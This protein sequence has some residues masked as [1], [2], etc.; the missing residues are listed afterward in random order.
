MNRLPCQYAVIRFLPYAETGEFANVGIVLACPAMGYLDS[1]LMPS[2]KTGRITGFF[3]QLDIRIYREA[4]KYLGDE[5][6]RVRKLAVDLRGDVVV[7]QLFEGLTRP[8]EAL[9]RF[10][11]VR[12]VLADDPEAMLDTL[13]ER[14]VERDFADKV[15]H[16]QALKR[17]VR[18]ALRKANLRD[19][20]QEAEIGNE[21]MHIQLPFVHKRDDGHAL[22]AIEPLDLAKDEAN[23]VYEAGG[24]WLARV[25]RFRRHKLLPDE[26]L[27]ALKLPAVANAR[28]RSAAEEI[29][30][31][32]REKPGIRV[33]GAEDAAAIAKFASAATH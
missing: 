15:Y 24:R 29:A 14:F 3:E 21:D 11:E 20:F 32:L 9:L 25:E 31:E 2:K 7:R 23:K 13:F 16:D 10:G 1:R 17:F 28:T 6:G 5:L 22:L 8:R 18:E 19:Y 27:F 30:A 12:A 33:A 4:L 26:M